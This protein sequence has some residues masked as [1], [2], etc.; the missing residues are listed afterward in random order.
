LG[1]E[2]AKNE[3]GRFGRKGEGGGGGGE[4]QEGGE[5][6]VEELTSFLGDGKRARV[7]DERDCWAGGP[8]LRL[9]GSHNCL[10][11]SFVL[12]K[13][14]T[15]PVIRFNLKRHVTLNFHSV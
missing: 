4:V 13:G 8:E 6:Q 7:W 1:R 11:S 15:Q 10:E 2:E 9:E 12:R 14:V 3:G 5:L